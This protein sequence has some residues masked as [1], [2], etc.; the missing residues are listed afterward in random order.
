[1]ADNAARRIKTE[2]AE[3]RRRGGI[4]SNGRDSENGRRRAAVKSKRQDGR[5]NAQRQERRNR[6]EKGG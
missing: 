2:V 3:R 6:T 4:M 5:Q 1:M